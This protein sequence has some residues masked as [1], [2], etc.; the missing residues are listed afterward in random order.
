MKGVASRRVAVE[1]LTKVESSG[2]YANI[3]LNEAFK[4]HQLSERDR[5][6]VTLIVQGVLRHQTELDE[7]IAGVSS[8]PLAQMPVL[9]KNTLRVAMFQLTHLKDIPE[10][11]V[12][13][14]ATEVAKLT[15]HKGTAK[16]VTGVLRGYLKKVKHEDAPDEHVPGARTAGSRPAARPAAKSPSGKQPA[17]VTPPAAEEPPEEKPPGE[18]LHEHGTPQSEVEFLGGEHGAKE[19]A[20]HPHAPPLSSAAAHQDRTP[21][22]RLAAQYSMPQWLVERWLSRYSET[23]TERLLASTQAVPLLT[24]R[25]C[26]TAVETEALVKILE[27]AGIKLR[28]GDLVDSC[29][30]IEDRGECKGPIDKLPGYS[31]GLFTVQDEAAA[32]ASKVVDAKPG[33]TIIDLCA[34]PGGK[35]VHMAEMMENKGRVIAVDIHAN[36]LNL[37]RQTRQRLGLTNIEIFQ[38]DGTTFSAG[39]SADRVLVDAPCTGTGVINRRSDIRVNRQPPDLDKLQALQQKLLSNAATMLKPGGV[40]VYAT[41]SI[42][43][44]EN[45]H[46]L[47]WFLDKYRNFAL[48]SIAPYVSS[49]DLRQRWKEELEQGWIQL[50]PTRHKTSGF[51]VA[52]LKKNVSETFQGVR[53]EET[54]AELTRATRQNVPAPP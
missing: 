16:F 50:L 22:Q 39:F 29:L 27:S 25:V 45:E 28:R 46:N 36:R 47:A 52:R 5:A 8:Q 41:C 13:N 30:I 37:L 43:P 53:V 42:E 33:E 44:E 48:E 34:A 35:T 12:L 54:I 38:E 7:L 23:E 3:A 9:L 49:T 18:T 15:G 21:A 6:F 20:K 4:H 11:A 24:V 32:F 2:A 51:F 10:S 19:R 14:T 1:A 31:D 40:L 26:E 17:N